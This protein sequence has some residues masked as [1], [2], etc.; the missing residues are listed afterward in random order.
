M[1]K[2]E[3]VRKT[4]Q[5]EASIL[6]QRAL[7]EAS[8]RETIERDLQSRNRSFARAAQDQVSG[9]LDTFIAEVK[10]SGDKRGDGVVGKAAELFPSFTR[11]F[12][13]LTR[14]RWELETKSYSVEDFGDADWNKR[15]VE[16][17]VVRAELVLQNR[18]LGRRDKVCFLLGA[19][20][21]AEFSYLRDPITLPCDSSEEDVRRWQ[22]GSRFSSRWKA[23][24]N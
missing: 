20:I 21:D 1:A 13:Q 3:E 19:V 23:A 4:L 8:K 15:K 5:Q 11:S 18:P 6:N 17:V 9:I 14:D 16:A 2:E 10:A 7:D 22:V 24:A 12:K